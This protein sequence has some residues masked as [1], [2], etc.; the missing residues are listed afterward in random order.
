MG[1]TPRWRSLD[2]QAQAATN[3]FIYALRCK[4]GTVLLDIGA[5]S[6]DYYSVPKECWSEDSGTDVTETRVVDDWADPVLA[7]RHI[8]YWIG[9]TWFFQSDTVPEDLCPEMVLRYS[10]AGEEDHG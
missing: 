3:V 8:W 1:A 10:C 2:P 6:D 4:V 7:H 5:D 9:E